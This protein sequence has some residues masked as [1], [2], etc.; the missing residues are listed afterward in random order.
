MALF[1]YIFMTPLEAFKTYYGYQAFRPMQEEVINSVLAGHDTLA[2]MPTGAGKSL[3]FII[4]TLISNR[5]TKSVTL[6]ISPLIALMKDQ[7]RSLK[8]RNIFASAI[9]TGMSYDNQRV[10]LDNCLYGPYP[11]LYVSPERLESEDFLARLNQLPIGLIVVDEAHCICEWGYDFR[12]AYLN[13]RNLIAEDGISAQWSHC[14]NGQALQR[15]AILA[16]TATATPV[17]ETDIVNQ[18]ALK[19]PVVFKTSFRRPNLRYVVRHCENKDA[20]LQQLQH[21]LSCVPGTAIVYVRNRKRAE[22]LA[23]LLKATF[24]HAGLD[25]K[26]R[27]EC[28]EAWQQGRERIIVCTNA[29]GMGIDK[30]D[31]RLVVHF[32]LPDSIEAYFQEAGRAGRDGLQSYCVLLFAKEDEAKVLR[33]IDTNYPPTE[34]VETV[35]HK[36]SDYFTIGAGSGLGHSFTLHMDE[37][38]RAMHLPLLPTLS[39]LHILDRAGYIRFEEERE[40]PPR[41]MINIPLNELRKLT[42]TDGSDL[43]DRLLRTHSGLMTDLQPLYEPLA[44][45]ELCELSSLAAR[46]IVTYVPRSTAPRVTYIQER[47]ETIFIP[48]IVYESRQEHYSSRL[49]TMLNYA[50]TYNDRSSADETETYLVNYF[51]ER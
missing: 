51:G 8:K 15:P 1:I 38:L 42:A 6:V 47:Q 48:P 17:V 25:A 36:L 40:S 43:L 46:D 32:D 31:V 16:L 20:K 7:V 44:E 49:R 21:I 23:T 3:T 12:P 45:A 37:F 9:Y 22:E 39:A 13:I 14:I 27:S 5:T 29:F 34:F 33:R 28:Q 2:L 18:L 30:P 19:N 35:Y 50:L 41:L 24:Y 26:T 11:F 4:P 10:A